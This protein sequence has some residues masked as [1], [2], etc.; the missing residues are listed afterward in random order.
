MRVFF[1]DKCESR[2]GEPCYT[3]LLLVE[4]LCPE[5]VWEQ[6]VWEEVGS[7]AMAG[8]EGEGWTFDRCAFLMDLFW[9]VFKTG[10]VKAERPHVELFPLK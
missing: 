7:A 2:A 5:D 4:G 3:N 1:N 10:T 8:A 6:R 9:E